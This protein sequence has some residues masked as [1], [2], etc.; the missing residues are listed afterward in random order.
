MCAQ[1]Q[2]QG[3]LIHSLQVIVQVPAELDEQRPQVQNLKHLYVH[4]YLPY[5]Q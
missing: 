5:I 2:S 4:I 1:C 3:T